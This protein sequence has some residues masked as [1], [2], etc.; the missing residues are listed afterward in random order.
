MSPRISPAGFLVGLIAGTAIVIGIRFG[1]DIYSRWFPEPAP[2]LPLLNAPDRPAPQTAPAPRDVAPVKPEPSPRAR[3]I[4]DIAAELARRAQ[5]CTFWS[6][7]ANDAS[8]KI[9]RDRACREMR[10]YA[11]STG[12]R[13]PSTDTRQRAPRI[14]TKPRKKSGVVRLNECKD[15]DYGSIRYRQC[16]ANE[17]QRLRTMCQFHRQRDEWQEAG[18]WCAA[19]ES[20]SI[21]D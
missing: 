16:R 21:V 20:Y 19:Y 3:S 2:V 11:A 14:E 9:Y 17:S 8:G 18:R 15:H 5:T 6:A 12:Q 10:R 7:R 13:V 4:E 1:P